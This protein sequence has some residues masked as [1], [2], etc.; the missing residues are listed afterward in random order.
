M[1]ISQVHRRFPCQPAHRRWIPNQHLMRHLA[2]HFPK[3]RLVEPLNSLEEFLE[4]QQ[5]SN[6]RLYRLHALALGM[7][8]GRLAGYHITLSR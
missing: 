3:L 5:L 1:T 4:S 2:A 8:H 7:L 6:G